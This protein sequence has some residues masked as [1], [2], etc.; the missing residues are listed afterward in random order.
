MFYVLY[1]LL[2]R[3]P[4]MSNMNTGQSGHVVQHVHYTINS[5]GDLTNKHLYLFLLKGVPPHLLVLTH[6]HKDPP[7]TLIVVQLMLTC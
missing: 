3:K 1:F 5:S 6:I 2:N 4:D 7:P